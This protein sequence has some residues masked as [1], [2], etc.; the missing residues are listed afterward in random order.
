MGAPRNKIKCTPAKGGRTST[1]TL[2]HTRTPARTRCRRPGV[3]A[4]VVS[5][6][7][8]KNTAFFGHVTK[9]GA[10][11]L[12]PFFFHNAIISQLSLPALPLLAVCGHAHALQVLGDDVGSEGRGGLSRKGFLPLLFVFPCWPGPSFTSLLFL[13]PRLAHTH[14]PL[15]C[16]GSSPPPTRRAGA[17]T[18]ATAPP[19]PCRAALARPPSPAAGAGRLVGAGADVD[20]PSPTSASREAADGSAM[21]GGGGGGGGGDGEAAPSSESLL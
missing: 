2:T 6:G 13:S 7:P 10:V 3:P 17:A 21:R 16:G 14:L 15:N 5:A 1:H 9:S 8:K 18:G 4:S 11:G 20:G 12:P 19:S